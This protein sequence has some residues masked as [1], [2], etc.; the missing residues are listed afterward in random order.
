MFDSNDQRQNQRIN[1][2]MSESR[3]LS[4]KF[5]ECNVRLFRLSHTEHKILCVSN[6]MCSALE[7]NQCSSSNWKPNKNRSVPHFSIST[8]SLGNRG[9]L[10]VNPNFS[11][12]TKIWFLTTNNK[13]TGPHVR[14]E[15]ECR[16]RLWHHNIP[17]G[18]TNIW[19]K[20]SA[21]SHFSSEA[22]V[23][24]FNRFLNQQSLHA[25]P[26]LLLLM[27]ETDVDSVLRL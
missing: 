10:Q 4:T 20:S 8:L 2:E 19:F 25:L 15:P 12:Q 16:L 7:L 23:C 17:W 3:H 6:G 26:D 22:T 9:L 13:E 11:V 24:L 1:W 14:H 5:I 18:C 27:W 21:L